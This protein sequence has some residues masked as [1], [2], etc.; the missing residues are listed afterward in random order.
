MNK[1]IIILLLLVFV[2]SCAPKNTVQVIEEH[3]KIETTIELSIWRNKMPS[4]TPSQFKVIAVFNGEIELLENIEEI[5][6]VACG[7][8]TP[9][10]E[11][12]SSLTMD[13]LPVYNN[14]GSTINFSLRGEA[15]FPDVIPS[16]TEVIGWML[17]FIDGTKIEIT[18][19]PAI[20]KDVY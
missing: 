9:E 4:M 19:E 20:V 15:D 18:T 1:S 10:G 5:R 3:S 6:F 7:V 11:E 13:S 8:K 14:P 17:F 12:L 2:F 16:N